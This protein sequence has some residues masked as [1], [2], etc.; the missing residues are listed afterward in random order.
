MS[1]D[2]AELKEFYNTS[3]GRYCAESL[4]IIIKELWP[5]LQ[6]GAVVGIGYP[7]PYLH[8]LSPLAERTLALMPAPQGV[9]HWP[10]GT[11]N[12]TCL[13]DEDL[14]PLAD[15]SIDRLLVIHSLEHTDSVKLYLRELWRIL[16]P[17]GHI[18]FITPNRRGLWAR[19][20][21]TPF[22]H[23]NPY[24]LTQL[25]NLLRENQFTITNMQRGLYLLPIYSSLLLKLS[26][27]I[28]YLP[29]PL[30]T[31]FSGIIAVEASKQV[32][33][34]YPTRSKKSSPILGLARTTRV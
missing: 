14:L 1:R 27:F 12:A 20:D 32:Y 5:S 13:I 2:I 25:N 19:F 10:M 18:I 11:K 31:K 26:R 3:L 6:G 21:N 22:G 8:S 17:H 34:I 23:G 4:S 24:T 33:N 9:C 29:K 7:L 30:I 16:A 15:N 28:D